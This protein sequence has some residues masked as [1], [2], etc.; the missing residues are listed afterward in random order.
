VLE[1]FRADDRGGVMG[2]STS[3]WLGI[4]LVAGCA[5]LWPVLKR[6]SEQAHAAARAATSEPSANP[7]GA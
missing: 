5:A 4:V 6:R 3:Q 2:L 1:F 7:E